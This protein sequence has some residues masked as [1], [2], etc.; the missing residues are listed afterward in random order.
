MPTFINEGPTM[1]PETTDLQLS[2]D[3]PT[4]TRHK[5]KVPTE[6]LIRVREAEPGMITGRDVVN[7]SG[8]LLY[9]EETE[10]TDKMIR[11]L[12]N[13]GQRCLH[14]KD[15][16][17]K[18]VDEAQYQRLP[19]EAERLETREVPVAD[20]G[21]ET[22][23]EP[24]PQE[25]PADGDA[26]A[27][28]QPPRNPLEY[29][30]TTDSLAELET[31]ADSLLTSRGSDEA[32]EE[33]EELLERIHNQDATY[34]EMLEYFISLISRAETSDARNQALNELENTGEADPVNLESD[35]V[36]DLMVEF[37]RTLENRDE[38]KHEFED[39]LHRNPDV[40]DDLNE[41]I[42]ESSSTTVSDEP[43]ADS[44]RTTPVE[45]LEAMKQS[46]REMLEEDDLRH[47]L[48][49]FLGS[50]LEDQGVKSLEAEDLFDGVGEEGTTPE[51]RDLPEDLSEEELETVD[52]V[53][54][55]FDPDQP[56]S[57]SEDAT[58]NEPGSDSVDDPTDPARALV[59]AFESLRQEQWKDAIQKMME[60]FETMSPETEPSMEVEDFLERSTELVD[61]KEAASERLQEEF[62]EQSEEELADHYLTL[63]SDSKVQDLVDEGLSDEVEQVLIEYF[64]N[65]YNFLSEL[66]EDLGD[67]IPGTLE[68]LDESASEDVMENFQ[69]IT[70]DLVLEGLREPLQ[71]S[72]FETKI[73][74]GEGLEDKIKER[75]EDAVKEQNFREIK[76]SS[77]L[78]DAVL[79]EFR[80]LYEKPEDLN[81]WQGKLMGD[82]QEILEHLVYRLEVP[83][84]DIDRYL[85]QFEQ[86]YEQKRK[87]FSLFVQPSNPVK[88]H[89]VH[90]YN[91]TL[92]SLMLCL[93][94]GLPVRVQKP[95]MIAASLSD[96]G[97]MFLPDS[98]YLKDGD[99][100]RRAEN[101]MRKH[102]LYSEKIVSEIV[103]SDHT[104]T[105]LV[106]E[107][108]ERMDG[109][110][111][112]RG[113][114]HGEA[115]SLT[116]ILTVADVYTALIEERAYRRARQPDR[117]LEFLE[118]RREKFNGKILEALTE[119]V[120]YYPNG[121]IVKLDNHRIA[122]VRSQNPETPRR[123]R[124]LFLT[125]ENRN[126]LNNPVQCDLS[127]PG[128]PSVELLLR[129]T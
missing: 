90:S 105:D 59:E 95:L 42:S 60:S 17:T 51:S 116:S 35:V 80:D 124:V 112:P 97:L 15:F 65:R 6:R 32:G 89:L 126:K 38:V 39:L 100:S 118:K 67:T 19:S 121:S 64:E 87:P 94:L 88:Y 127:E 99:L 63:D 125:D 29:L 98:F 76:S 50:L 62:P 21:T 102:P 57:G 54:G 84:D 33:L 79:E 74:S 9:P 58:G 49:S 81:K 20:T 122:F 46:L 82:H 77:R 13:F 61:E 3:Q 24:A 96:V 45:T 117:A 12:R 71:Q 2:D 69:S 30:E 93:E 37:E 53:L 75:L 68:D 18:W 104:I 22:E 28:D 11:R 91:V 114:K 56:A 113:Y 66:W 111:Y 7:D 43:P 8:Q 78:P 123:P 48:L 101:E 36:Q 26:S 83:G 72:F 34:D 52:S 1:N 107:H 129:A 25:E 14:I 106:G 73:P 108:H 110:G 92:L 31:L 41:D 16:K 120:G 40:V 4:E 27:G 128:T 86:V 55:V 103:G 109:S 10:L 44:S 115:S 47:N 70:D 5:V 85:S 119:A 23:E